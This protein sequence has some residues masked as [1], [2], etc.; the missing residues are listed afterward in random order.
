MKRRA[1]PLLVS[2]ALAVVAV[3][4]IS[5]SAL[6]APNYPIAGS[7]Q[8]LNVPVAPGTFQPTIFA[9][10]P[11]AAQWGI[12]YAPFV[13]DLDDWMAF[14]F[15]WRCSKP[16]T[17]ALFS[18][19]DDLVGAAQSI[20]GSLF[21]PGELAAVRSQSTYLIAANQPV[22]ALNA[23]AGWLLLVNV[24][25]NSAKNNLLALEGLYASVNSKTTVQLP[26]GTSDGITYVENS[27]ARLF[28]ELMMLDT[29]GNSGPAW[30]REGL[31][32]VVAFRT[33]PGTQPDWNRPYMLADALQQNYPVPS[34]RDLTANWAGWAGAGGKKAEV[35]MGVADKSVGGLCDMAGYGKTLGILKRA[36]A[37]EDLDSV[38]GAVTGMNM[39]QLYA[40]WQASLPKP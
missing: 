36:A 15:G 40:S 4:A 16:F 30:L 27:I 33:V 29:I 13:M 23:P 9:S 28:T 31:A 20:R 19:S 2:L 7:S 38:L 26:F 34:L 18:N 22:A 8:T 17:V 10:D 11:V 5:G 12:T 14:Q 6:A 1:L 37:G 35:S 32:D 24:D 25:L 39:D 21:T 3:L